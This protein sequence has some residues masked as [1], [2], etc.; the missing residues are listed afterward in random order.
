MR[1]RNPVV[2][3]SDLEKYINATLKESGENFKNAV[4]NKNYKDIDEGFR[5]NCEKV[6]IDFYNLVDV[7]PN[8]DRKI[9]ERKHIVYQVS[10]LFKFY[11]RT[12]LTLDIDWIE[13]HSRPENC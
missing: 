11:E 12:F 2:W 3:N 1:D 8:I 9:G 7:D 13:S 5:L 10:A 6:L 4:R